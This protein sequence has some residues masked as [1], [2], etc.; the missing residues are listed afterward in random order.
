MAK[1]GRF[2]VIEG[3]DG[4]GKTTQFHLL[5]KK[6][7]SQNINL[8]IAE[9]PRYYASPWGRLVGRFLTGEF[10]RLENV[11]PYLV[12]LPYMIDQYTWS[13]DIA[14]PWIEEGGWIL[15]NRYFTSNAH[16]IAKLK[17]RARKKFR[18]WMWPLGYKSLGILKPDLVVFIDTE[19]HIAKQ[20]INSKNER[21]YLNGKRKDI[22]ESNWNHQ[23]SAY[24]EYKKCVD[25]YKWW[26]SVPGVKDADKDFSKAIHQDVWKIVKRRCF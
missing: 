4:S 6:L 18:D 24:N 7:E 23:V 12:V 14:T 5:K 26:V 2:I 8:L 11:S 9:F 17:T 25:A 20:L 22:A 15:T 19:P 16:Q 3:I 1:R 13:R 10:G 21:S